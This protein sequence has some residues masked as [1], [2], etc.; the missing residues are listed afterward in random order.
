MIDARCNQNGNGYFNQRIEFVLFDCVAI[1]MVTE[2][3]YG[4]A[5]HKTE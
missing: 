4:D 2:L 1:T 5:K 3:N